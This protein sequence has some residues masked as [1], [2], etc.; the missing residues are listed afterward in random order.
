MLAVSYIFSHA[1]LPSQLNNT[2][3]EFDFDYKSLLL[4]KCS[5]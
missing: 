2:L 3:M 4:I 5:L 1:M